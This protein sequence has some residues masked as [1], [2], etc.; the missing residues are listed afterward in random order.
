MLPRINAEMPGGL[1]WGLAHIGTGWGSITYGTEGAGPQRFGQT[2]AVSPKVATDPAA[3]TVTFF[4]EGALLGV[5]DWTGASIY[6]TTW[7]SA[8]SGLAPE[9]SEWAFGG[10][11]PDEP[12]IMDDILLE[13]GGTN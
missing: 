6:I 9:P 11:E 2:L 10:G 12:R 4:Y 3:R 7:D 5:D 1:T 8:Y 13:L